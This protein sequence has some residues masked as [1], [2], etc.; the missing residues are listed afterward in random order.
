MET[1][2]KTF[3]RGEEGF[4]REGKS[5]LASSL[6]DCTLKGIH[7]KHSRKMEFISPEMARKMTFSIFFQQLKAKI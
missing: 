4:E 5:Y 3:V 2:K 6:P 1:A 7:H